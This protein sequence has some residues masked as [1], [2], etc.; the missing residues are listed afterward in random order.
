MRIYNRYIVSL[1]LVSCFINTLLA[2]YG[3]N[4]LEIYFVI[5]IL[6]YLVVTQLYVY[7]RPRAKKA[8]S[9]VGAVLIAGFMVIIVF[10][11][12]TLILGR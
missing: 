5:N 7:I 6:A 9:T 1:V 10:K 3:Q 12:M 8:L 4:K 2:F 11:V